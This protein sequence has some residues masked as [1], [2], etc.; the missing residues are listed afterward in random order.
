M[1]YHFEYYFANHIEEDIQEWEVLLT[2]EE[3]QDYKEE[4]TDP[5]EAARSI[6]MNEIVDIEAA[7][8]QAVSGRNIDPE[9]LR[10]MLR[11]ELTEIEPDTDSEDD[12][13]ENDDPEPKED[14][15]TDKVTHTVTINRIIS[16]DDEVIIK[17]TTR[18]TRITKTLKTNTNTDDR[19]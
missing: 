2:H 3:E 11:I 15:W 10:N 19:V 4:G 17:K 12:T 18:I 6:A 8:Q 13:D 16:E 14:E 5:I 1:T 7:T 9:L